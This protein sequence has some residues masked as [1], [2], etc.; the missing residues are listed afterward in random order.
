MCSLFPFFFL[1]SL[2]FFF[3]C[4]WYTHVYTYVFRCAV[5]CMHMETRDQCRVSS[6]SSS[7]LFLW[8]WVSHWTWLATKLPGSSW[9]HLPELSYTQLFLKVPEIW[10][11][12][13][14]LMKQ[15]FSPLSHLLGAS[16]FLKDIFQTNFWFYGPLFNS[17]PWHLFLS[18]F[19]TSTK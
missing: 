11:Q 18:K 12:V 3:V 1:P 17:L 14:V 2:F 7:A 19:H 16:S 9:V 5:L 15:L 8:D 6:L 10:T 13:F 4:M